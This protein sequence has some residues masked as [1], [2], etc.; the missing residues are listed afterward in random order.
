MSTNESSRW[1]DLS[2]SQHLL[3]FA[4]P[5][6]YMNAP[7]SSSLN[8]TRPQCSP[9]DL[10]CLSCCPRTAR[11]VRRQ[12]SLSLRVRRPPVW[13][14][15]RKSGNKQRTQTYAQTRICMCRRVLGLMASEVA[16]GAAGGPRL[17]PTSS[18]HR[19]SG[20][21]NSSRQRPISPHPRLCQGLEIASGCEGEC[22][23]MFGREWI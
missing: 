11:C 16:A 23:G 19:F 20:C 9:L 17:L 8:P 12:S 7:P 6:A 14:S 18:R 13:E 2:I 5:I 22:V 1:P 3:R 10:F 21:L 4:N 15:H